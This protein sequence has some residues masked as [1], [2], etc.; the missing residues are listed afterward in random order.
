MENNLNI[1]RFRIRSGTWYAEL[2]DSGS[3]KGIYYSEELRQML[4]YRSK[5][6]F[7][8]ELDSFTNTIFPDDV[9]IMLRA[10][11]D[12]AAG[13]TDR[14]DVEYRI[15]HRSGEYIF[16]NDVGRL[17]RAANGKP[18]MMHGA[19]IDVTPVKENDA[20]KTTSIKDIIK[21]AYQEDSARW[22][23]TVYDLNESARFRLDYDEN[24]RL[25]A[26]S[27]NDAYWKMLGYSNANELPQNWPTWFNSII[28]EDKEMILAAMD[29]ISNLTDPRDI[30]EE[31]FRVYN[32]DR[33]M[34]WI[35]MAT[36]RVIDTEGHP[37]QVVGIVTD[38]SS[39]KQSELQTKIF[40]IFSREYVTVNIVD[41]I[42]HKLRILRYYER[43]DTMDALNN[44][45]K[46]YNY[47]QVLMHYIDNYVAPEDR[48]R[49]H[50][51]TAIDHLV[52]QVNAK[53][54]YR[55]Q[56][57]QIDK[58]GER[59][60]Y[61]GS[62]IKLMDETG[63][64]A[65]VSGYR[66]ITDIVEEEKKKQAALQKAMEEAE[67]A[68]HAKTAFLFNM[69]H[70]IRTPMNAIMGYRDLLEKYQEDPSRRKYYLTRMDEVS[71]IL[72]SIID[73]VLEMAR[74]EKG[75]LELDETVWNIY[76]F[77][78]YLYSVFMPM[79]EKKGLKFNRSINITNAYIWCDSGKLRD[80]CINILTNA[81]KYTLEGGTVSLTVEEQPCDRDGWAVYQTTISDTGIGMAEDFLPRIFDAFTREK[82]SSGNKIEGTGLGMSI[83]KRLVD[84]LGGTVEVESKKGEGSTFILRIPHRIAAK[85]DHVN[86]RAVECKP[87]I[88]K[89]KRALL[90]EDNDIN[91]EIATEILSDL[92]I[93][94]EHAAD[95]EIC[96][97]MLVNA[98]PEYYDFILMDIQMPNMNGY[99][100]TE[101][102]RTLTDREK[103]N[104]PI[105]AMTA[106]AFDE[107]KKAAFKAGMNG[108]L[109]KPVDV[110]ELVRGIA[111]V[112][113]K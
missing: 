39:R 52:Q 56:F 108:H 91:A 10:V 13:K 21:K 20:K 81:Y 101:A 29:V 93:E 65:I 5:D 3:I 87:E 23:G 67:A 95:G 63:N 54:M 109:A 37:K 90:A 66:D 45:R 14:F 78:D 77:T 32:K 33:S 98:P 49:M 46:D 55:I 72:L 68:N 96:V 27:W 82:N 44:L 100:A 71:H 48:E 113:K 34:H 61:Q 110:D 74:I 36:R 2:S 106:N 30:H 7:P 22:F 88:L 19:V 94:T 12:T 40:N 53:K 15:R 59:H 31:E 79:M 47:E 112:L 38:I 105:L 42:N 103:S 69:S 104:I 99:E 60:H 76:Q 18:F 25:M 58:N 64:P 85:E 102:I 8:D 50:K 83:V 1:E 107:D 28:P 89:G 41:I 6:E 84:F 11:N 17:V 75:T 16:V 73:N 80:I 57:S 70:D 86:R 111:G 92:G 97:D 51:L 9:N 4:G 24:G 35:H 43:E 62:Y 26:I